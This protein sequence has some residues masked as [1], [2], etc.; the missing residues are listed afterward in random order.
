M[1]NT[2][3]LMGSISSEKNV[4]RLGQ[5][6]RTQRIGFGLCFEKNC[7]SNVFFV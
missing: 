2:E 4:W 6:K 7:N 5:H 1:P 3:N